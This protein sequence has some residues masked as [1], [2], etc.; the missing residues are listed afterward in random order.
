MMVIM[1]V[2]I[3]LHAV[4]VCIHR[5]LEDVQEELVVAART[6]YVEWISFAV[7]IDGIRFVQ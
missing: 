5:N 4:N 3:G 2:M 1:I 6:K 7:R